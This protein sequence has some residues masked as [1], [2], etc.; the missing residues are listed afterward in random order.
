[1]QLTGSL[2]LRPTV[3]ATMTALK[4]CMLFFKQAAEAAAAARHRQPGLSSQ[5][6]VQHCRHGNT[7]VL[8]CKQAVVAGGQPAAAIAAGS[9]GFPTAVSANINF[10]NTPGCCSSSRPPR[11]EGS[12]LLLPATGS[13]GLWI[14]DHP[15]VAPSLAK[16]GAAEVLAT[17]VRVAAARQLPKVRSLAFSLESY[18]SI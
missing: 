9:L 1:M 17:G 11:L 7:W 12:L 2:G 15:A 18:R 13:L 5:Q 3:C 14:A 16:D 6:R 4:P 10:V 8:F